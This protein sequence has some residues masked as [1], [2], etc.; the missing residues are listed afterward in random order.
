[1]KK[2]IVTKEDERPAGKGSGHCFYCPSKIGEEHAKE[3]VLRKRKVI[4]RLAVEYPIEVPESWTKEQIEFH[5]NES[6]WCKDNALDE[7][8]EFIKQNGCL[9]DKADI[10]YVE[11][12]KN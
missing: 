7:L 8:K 3:C 11:E 1:M 6:S 4:I 9:C 10:E 5:R 12:C 2:F